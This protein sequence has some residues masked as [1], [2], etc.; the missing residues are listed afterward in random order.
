VIGLSSS[1]YYAKPKIPREQRERQDADLRD[2]IERVQAELTPTGYRSVLRY[3][4]RQG[5]TAGERKIR[6]IMKKYALHAKLKRAFVATTDSE[7]SHRV[8]PNLLP[9]RTVMGLDEVWTADLTY[10]RIG[11]GFV[12]LAVVL[13]LYS[14][15]VIGWSISK[16][17][18]GELALAALRMAITQ[19]QPKSGCIH[20]SD[21]GVQ[22]LCGEYVARLE[23]HGF[24]ISN[25]AKGNP[26]D[27][28]W[29]ERF[30][31]TLKQEEVYLANYETYLDV[32]ENLPTFIEDVYNE[33]RIHSGIDYLTPNELEERVRKNPSNPDNRRFDLLL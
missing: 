33:R 28:A 23:Q 27:N 21:R 19:R 29:T 24:W 9:G 13:D 25:S 1:T 11:N 32:I 15:R 3:L 18:D 20:H 31:R 10:I 6:R 12:Y 26:Y 16:R 4:R 2:Q 7:H 22:Y 17:I 8:Y 14:R 5:N 30:M